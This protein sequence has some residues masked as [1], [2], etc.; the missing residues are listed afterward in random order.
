[1]EEWNSGGP[2]PGVPEYDY[3]KIVHGEQKVETIQPFPVEGGRFKLVRSCTGVYDK[4]S[5]MLID[6]ALDVYGEQNNVHYC[7]LETKMFVRGYGGWDVKCF[8][9]CQINQKTN[10]FI[11]IQGPKGPKP[12]TYNPPSREPDA[13]DVWKTNANQALLYRLSGDYNPLHADTALAPTV[14]FPRPI[15]HG[16][17]SYGKCTHAVIKHFGGND[18]HRFKSINARFA[19]PVFPGETI[20]VL[21]WKVA[22]NDPK[23]DGIIFQARVKER[24]VVVLSNGYA[25]LYKEEKNEAKL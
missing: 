20:E 9:V 8:I 21:M 5:G 23:L 25:E 18:S 7:R 12:E 24:N 15:L 16:L 1:M 2:L 11:H 6:T 10:K 4:G 14:G 3:N 17:C 22:T 19:Q 13:V